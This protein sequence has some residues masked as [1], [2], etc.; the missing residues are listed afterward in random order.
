MKTFN[1]YYAL[2]DF[3]KSFNVNNNMTTNYSQ[4]LISFLVDKS[5][6]N[7]L[8]KIENSIGHDT[9]F[10]NVWNKIVDGFKEEQLGTDSHFIK[11]MLSFIFNKTIYLPEGEV[12]TKEWIVHKYN[13][14]TTLVD[15]GNFSPKEL[16][17]FNQCKNCNG[18][19]DLQFINWQPSLMEM[20]LV[21]DD[22]DWQKREYEYQPA[23]PDNNIVP[24]F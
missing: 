8:K 18:I 22:I 14:F 20:V 5:K 7:E 11:N 3:K 19:F 23:S 21:K 24:K 12:M 2:E 6:A 16:P 4:A 9:G 17:P 1:Q 10:G 13:L 15:N